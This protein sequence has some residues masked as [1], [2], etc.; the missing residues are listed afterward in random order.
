M[1]LDLDDAVALAG[2]AAP[3]F[4]VEGEA[5]RP[6][7]A[8]ARHR[9]AREKLADRREQRR[10]SGGVGWRGAADRALIDA[11]RLVEELQPLDRVVRGGLVH[12]AVEL[13]CDGVIQRVVDER[14]FARAGDAGDAHEQ[15]YWQ[16]EIDILEIVPARPAQPEDPRPV[17][18]AA[19]LGHGDLERTDRKSTRLN[20][21]HLGISYAVFC[22]K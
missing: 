9:H 11:H 22:L 6:V 8:L 4:H 1:H 13:A 17:E 18:T 10:V 7:A 20:S 5:P 14:R 21:S 19:V 3:A 12:R 15:A 16:R 2:F